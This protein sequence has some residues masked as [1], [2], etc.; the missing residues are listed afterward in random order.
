M[1]IIRCSSTQK[2][3]QQASKILRSLLVNEKHNKNDVLLLLSGGS[4]FLLLDEI[5]NDVLGPHVTI[6]MLDERYSDD[7]SVNNF[8]QFMETRFYKQA[9]N[10]GTALIDSRALRNETQKELAMRFENALRIWKENHKKGVIVATVGIGAD[11][12]TAGIMPFTKNSESFYALFE[13]TTN[14][15]TSYDAG[16]KNLYPLRVTVTLLFLRKQIDHAIVFA[17]GKEKKNA[18]ERVL[19]EGGSLAETPARIVRE[20]K[21]ATA[22]LY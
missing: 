2:A 20:M 9:V 18:L 19:A 5:N 16:N 7:Q 22:V 8:T 13:H 15:V 3:K 1:K 14:W 6:S 10:T 4:A 11:G 21:N 17:I 12:H